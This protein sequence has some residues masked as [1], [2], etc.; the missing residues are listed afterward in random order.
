MKWGHMH[1]CRYM[2]FCIYIIRLLLHVLCICTQ[3]SDLGHLQTT[4]SCG[5]ICL[6]CWP[7]SVQCMQPIHIYSKESTS[8]A[9]HLTYQTPIPPS[10]H[11]MDCNNMHMHTCPYM[12]IYIYQ[13]MALSASCAGHT[14]TQSHA[15]LYK[16]N[17]EV[18]H[19]GMVASYYKRGSE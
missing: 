17:N 12:A 2:Q 5:W 3:D 11:C 10:N 18:V 13:S 9:Q 4:S 1:T 14:R 19:S 15:A 6:G 16:I 7:S 8:H